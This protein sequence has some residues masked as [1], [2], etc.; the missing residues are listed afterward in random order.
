M[1]DD[2]RKR[3]YFT[4]LVNTV[5][6]SSV[7]VVGTSNARSLA[8]FEM[9]ARRCLSLMLCAFRGAVS[10]LALPGA[11]WPEVDFNDQELAANA[12]AFSKWE[13]TAWGL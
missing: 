4:A 12:S 1:I 8:A 11:G 5:A 10:F 3:T 6:L 2:L 13:F 9:S 7:A